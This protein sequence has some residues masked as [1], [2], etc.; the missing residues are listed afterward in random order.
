M[1]Q[2][3]NPVAESHIGPRIQRVPVCVVGRN[4]VQEIDGLIVPGS[5]HMVFSRFQFR[6]RIA[7]GF[8]TCLLIALLPAEKS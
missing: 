6:I 5:Q 1:I 7:A 4:S 2:G 3:G 8:E